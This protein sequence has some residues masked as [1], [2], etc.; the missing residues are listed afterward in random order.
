MA[1]FDELKKN[2]TKATQTVAQKGRDIADITKMNIAVA[3]AEKKLDE[4]Y[5]KVG[6]LF[7][8]KVGDRAEGDFADLVNEIKEC[9]AKI[10]EYKQ[11]VKDIKGVVA[12]PKCGN[13][14]SSD[15]LFCNACG[16]K[17]NKE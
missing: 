9:K 8:E 3:E 12:C 17:L 4:L 6:C 5:K 14:L 13:E 2:V 15:A 10:D 16:E 1:F 7:V 11:Q